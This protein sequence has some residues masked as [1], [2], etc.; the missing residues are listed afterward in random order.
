MSYFL[1]NPFNISTVWQTKSVTLDITV[2]IFTS[3]VHTVTT[4]IYLHIFKS[5]PYCQPCMQFWVLHLTPK[6]IRIFLYVQNY[7]GCWTNNIEYYLLIL[8]ADALD[9]IC[10]LP[11]GKPPSL[12]LPS[13]SFSWTS[14]NSVLHDRKGTT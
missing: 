5:W 6:S 9:W 1:L 12:T 3:P 10:L 2:G 14:E 4:S 13:T 11:L 7:I 8:E